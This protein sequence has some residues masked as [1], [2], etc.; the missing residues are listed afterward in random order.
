[1]DYSSTLLEFVSECEKNCKP[2]F[3]SA[4]QVALICQSKVLNAFRN[5]GV[6]E[7]HLKGTLGYGY[8]DIGRDT[9]CKVFAEAFDAEQ[10]LVSPN[11]VSG[12]HAL[13]LAL[14]GLLRP[15]DLL[16]SITGKPYDTLDNVINGNGN[17]SLKDFGIKYGEIALKKSKIDLETVKSEVLNQQPKV[18][19]ITRSKGYE[20]RD[21]LTVAEIGEAIKAVKKLAPDVT[22]MVDNCY[23]EFIEAIEPTNVGADVIVGSLIK[24]AGGGIAP[25][26][27]YIAGKSKAVELISYRLTAPSIGNEVGSYAAGYANFY[28]GFFLAP[29]TVLNAVKTGILFGEAFSR[30][31]YETMPKAGERVKDI[32][33]SIKFKD[34][35]KLVEFC[36]LIQSAS[37]I[38]GYV[39][40]EPWDMPG[41]QD[42]VIMA[43][44][45]F[46][47][48]ASIELSAD[49]PIKPPYIGYMQGSLTY[50]HGKLALLTVLQKFFN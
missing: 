44:G 6:S 36:R 9:L 11:I 23:G 38:D 34:E 13:T 45:T 46:V 37:P 33:R 21:A 30:L 8:D 16:L 40:P 17:G 47:A 4:E 39:T 35:D 28:E 20:W 31:G 18:V 2:L 3:E 24:N 22:V 5:N 7:R 48:G 1:M 14:F 32:I 19:F 50:E 12:T 42:K 10:A 27:A 15:N 49:A 43:A 26:G 25:T 41:Y 29:H